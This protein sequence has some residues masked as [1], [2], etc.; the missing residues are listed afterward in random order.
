[1]PIIFAHRY[2]TR[3]RSAGGE[4]H[5]PLTESEFEQR[6][7]YGCFAMSWSSHGLRYGIGTEINSWLGLGLDVVVNGSR[8]YLEKASAAFAGLVPVLI[9]ASEITLRHRL[10]D[11]G[12]ENAA[13]RE[14]R[15]ARAAALNSE[16]DHPA[17]VT[18]ENNAALDQAGN[19]LLA[20]LCEP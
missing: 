20:L 10:A 14:Q 1:L 17:L 2:I 18:I 11:R 15:I 16:I 7:R 8:A 4:D 5:I 9:E 6:E 12:R 19:R 13:D 3:A